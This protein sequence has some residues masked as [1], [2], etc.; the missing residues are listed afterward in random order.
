MV[1]AQTRI[2]PGKRDAQTL[3]GFW[4]TD[5]SPSL[6]ETTRTGDSQQ[7]K[8]LL[9]SE[10]FCFSWPLGETKGKRKTKDK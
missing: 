3:L 2:H 9:N 5:G 6:S 4:D 8:N 7:K 10:L 1:N